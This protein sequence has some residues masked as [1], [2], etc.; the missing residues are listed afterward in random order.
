[1]EPWLSDWRGRIRGNAAALLSPANVGEV[2]QI[3][4]LAA[5]AGVAIVP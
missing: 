2:E 5:A 4:R 1:M 3:V